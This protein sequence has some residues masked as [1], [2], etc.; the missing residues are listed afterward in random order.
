MN[1]NYGFAFT[2]ALGLFSAACGGAEAGFKEP[3]SAEAKNAPLPPPSPPGRGFDND[4][5]WQIAD[6]AAVKVLENTSFGEQEIEQFWLRKGWHLTQKEDR[7]LETV[8]RL[9][10]E[11]TIKKTAHWAMTPYTPVYAAQETV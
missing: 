2:F 9:A 8:D 7:Y 11:G 3:I 4:H 5:R 6:P 1:T 10:G